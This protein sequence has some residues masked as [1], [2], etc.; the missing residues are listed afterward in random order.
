MTQTILGFLLHLTILKD[1]SVQQYL[2]CCQPWMV[3]FGVIWSCVVI[4]FCVVK[5]CALQIKSRIL[6]CFTSHKICQFYK[7]RSSRVCYHLRCDRERFLRASFLFHLSI[8]TILN[9]SYLYL[10]FEVIRHYWCH[11]LSKYSHWY[12]HSKYSYYMITPNEEF[13][14]RYYRVSW[15]V[16][17]HHPPLGSI[18]TRIG[19]TKD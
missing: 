18:D 2:H 8:E 6:I 13:V 5:T 19:L 1:W 9:F 11:Q 16:I 14:Y 12:Y 4:L 17:A 7:E 15:R 3:S 10:T